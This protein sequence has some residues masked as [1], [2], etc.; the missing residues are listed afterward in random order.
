MSIRASSYLDEVV[1][2][3]PKALFSQFRRLGIYRWEDV[4]NKANRQVDQDI[5]AF[6]FSNTEVFSTPISRADLQEIWREETGGRF[7]IQS[8]ISIPKQRFFRLY[9]M[10]VQT[11]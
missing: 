9:R 8:P 2:D 6:R 5:M 1:V 3:K 7:H 10:G 4:F 11:Q